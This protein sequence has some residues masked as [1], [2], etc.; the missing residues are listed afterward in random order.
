MDV[1]PPL[2]GRLANLFNMAT[3]QPATSAEFREFLARVAAGRVTAEDWNQHAVTRYADAAVE[4]ARREL[5]R[6]ALLCGQCSMEPVQGDLSGVAEGL[7][8]ELADLT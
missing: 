6:A 4:K 8:A 3:A 1:L 7:L 5:V 2:I